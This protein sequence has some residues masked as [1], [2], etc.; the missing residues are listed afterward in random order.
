MRASVAIVTY[1]KTESN[2]KKQPISLNT[3]TRSSINNMNIRSYSASGYITTNPH[4]EREK[5]IT[6]IRKSIKTGNRSF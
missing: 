5:Q 6:W 1:F 3:C 2:I 4:T